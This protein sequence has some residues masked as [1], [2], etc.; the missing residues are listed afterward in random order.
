MS[1]QIAQLSQ[2]IE[3]LIGVVDG[4]SDHLQKIAQQQSIIINELTQDPEDGTQMADC[5]RQILSK[6]TELDNKQA[7]VLKHITRT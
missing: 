1:D 7:V 4:L 6:L 2:L 3:T 5:L